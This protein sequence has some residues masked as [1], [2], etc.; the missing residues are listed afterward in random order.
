M[1][2]TVQEQRANCAKLIAILEQVPDEKYDHTYL[3]MD[4]QCGTTACALG[5]AGLSEQFPGL[6]FNTDRGSFVRIREK[7]INELADE[8]FGRG[9]YDAVFSELD[10]DDE[11]R[12]WNRHDVIDALRRHM[13]GLV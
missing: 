9:S 3:Y 6:E 2:L 4:V 1:S 11:D 5:H 7:R 12:E 13:E 10:D 8:T